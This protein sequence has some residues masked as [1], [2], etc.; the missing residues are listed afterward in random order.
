MD[1]LTLEMKFV[2]LLNLVRGEEP[3]ALDWTKSGNK[4]AY[5]FEIGEYQ[6]AFEAW[7][8]FE[9]LLIP[10]EE[11]KALGRS[12]QGLWNLIQHNE[13]ED[14]NVAAAYNQGFE[15]N[16]LHPLVKDIELWEEVN[17]VEL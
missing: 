12:C 3:N 7:E 14:F 13:Y 10:T 16:P 4:N 2:I 1:D 5:S 9:P 11:A 15:L 6:K 8:N 17:A